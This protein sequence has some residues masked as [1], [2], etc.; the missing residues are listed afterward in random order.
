MQELTKASLRSN[1]L[2]SIGDFLYEEQFATSEHLK[3]GILEIINSISD[4]Q[5]EGRTLFPEIII[6]DNLKYFE[7]IPNRELTIKVTKLSKDEFRNALKLCAPLAKDS[8]VI[9]IEVSGDNMKYGI[10]SAEM[11]ETSPSLYKQTVGELGLG[12]TYKEGKIAYIKNIGQK[13]VELVGLKKRMIIYLTLDEAPDVSQNEV[14]SVVS[15]ITQ[16]CDPKIQVN[17]QA[18]FEKVIDEAL[19]DGHGN[20]IGVVDYQSHS[21]Q[22]LKELITSEGGIYLIEPIDFEFL[23]KE[24]EDN[25]TN[26][27]SINLKSYA[28]VAKSMLNHDGITIFTTTGKLIA[29]HILIG[30]FINDGDSISGGARSKAFKSMENCRKFI[31]GFCKSQDGNIKFWKI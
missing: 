12:D 1:I 29:Y 14:K 9:F 27:T 4:Y 23:I 2:S 15:Q 30:E 19:K 21:I 5:E 17:L 31:A 24:A 20:L 25:K 3:Y 22:E 26:E 8:W 16:H 7:S 10:T 18:F 13:T 6:T 28:S 11:S